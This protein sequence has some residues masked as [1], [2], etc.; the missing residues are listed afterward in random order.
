MSKD[1]YQI[2]GIDKNAGQEQ[3]KA[4]YRKLAFQHHPDRNKKDPAA[5][6]KM[7]EINEA[8]A[9]LS[10]Q[11]KRKKYDIFRDSYGSSASQRFRESYSEED[12]FRD[13]DINQIFEEMSK[14]FGFRNSDEIFKEFY[15]SRYQ[16]FSFRRRGAFGRGS[17]SF[18]GF[19]PHVRRQGEFRGRGKEQ[20]PP[21]GIFANLLNRYLRHKIGKTFGVKFPE[22][23]ADLHDVLALN[24]KQAQRG[25]KVKYFLR[26][27]GR[28]KEIMV[29]IPPGIRDNQRI[30]LKGLG[31]EGRDGG[32]AGDLYLEVMI[33]VP[34]LQ[35]IKNFFAG[36]KN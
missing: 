23:G 30:R 25:E 13:S 4:A 9:I 3:I 20:Q 11:K 17:V 8:Y 7:K 14:I 18:Y 21:L 29:K 5:G 16:T 15:G 2:L 35:R 32:E 19:R 34:L 36:D 26:G 33:R 6:E 28:P 31:A 10:D 1:Y 27:R 22:R 12:I 24:P